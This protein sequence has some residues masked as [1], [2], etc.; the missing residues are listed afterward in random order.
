MGLQNALPSDAKAG[1]RQDHPHYA[2]GIVA[3]NMGSSRMAPKR[4]DNEWG[5]RLTARG[6]LVYQERYTSEIAV[7]RI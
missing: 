4:C 5:V 2:L 6:K 1:R 3:I 7:S